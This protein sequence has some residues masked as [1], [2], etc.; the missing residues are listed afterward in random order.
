VK[1]SE[2]GV[3]PKL[4]TCPVGEPTQ[5]IRPPSHLVPHLRGRGA[6]TREGYG[7]TTVAQ[8]AE[9]AQVTANTVY[10]SVGGKPQLLAQSWKTAPAIPPSPKR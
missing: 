2:P 1:Y 3:W 10:T 9:A 5:T 4:P 8:I 7:R 6:D